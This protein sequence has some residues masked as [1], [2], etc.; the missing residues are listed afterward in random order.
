MTVVH[1]QLVNVAPDIVV[2][3]GMPGQWSP[4]DSK[5]SSN[6]FSEV[7]VQPGLPPALLNLSSSEVI[8]GYRPPKPAELIAADFKRREDQEAASPTPPHKAVLQITKPVPVMAVAADAEQRHTSRSLTEKPMGRRPGF[9]AP[10]SNN[11]RPP[12]AQDLRR[13]RREPLPRFV[14]MGLALAVGVAMVLFLLTS[15]L[16]VMESGWIDAAKVEFEQLDFPDLFWFV[17]GQENTQP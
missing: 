5:I 4:P 11:P 2:A 17:M 13:G 1:I 16:G 9:I 12:S 7:L 14:R 6:P 8:V 10:A 15:I 3:P